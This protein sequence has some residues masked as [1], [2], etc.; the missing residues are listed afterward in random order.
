M[1]IRLTCSR[2]GR[3]STQNRSRHTTGKTLWGRE[4]FHTR[5]T[6]NRTQCGRDCSDWLHMGTRELRDVMTDSNLCQ[7][8]LSSMRILASTLT[9]REG[10]K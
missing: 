7:H 6:D 5:L 10:E 9:Q 2:T 1:D 8:C 4:V 3:A